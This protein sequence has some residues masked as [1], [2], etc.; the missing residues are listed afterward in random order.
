[1]C[2]SILIVQLSYTFIIYYSSAPEGFTCGKL[3]LHHAQLVSDNWNFANNWPKKVSYLRELIGNF[4]NRAVFADD[5][6]DTPI[7]WCIEKPSGEL[8]IAFVAEKYRNK[9]LFKVV[10]SGIA[11]ATLRNGFYP[12]YVVK[13]KDAPSA[14]NNPFEQPFGDTLKAFFICKLC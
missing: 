8:G 4:E 11:S 7:A 9:G 14:P 12:V 3:Q 2:S 5:N 6:P 1:M 10:R 13:N